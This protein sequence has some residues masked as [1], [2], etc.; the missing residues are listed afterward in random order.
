MGSA[1][2][3]QEETQGLE[4]SGTGQSGVSGLRRRSDSAADGDIDIDAI[5]ADLSR[6]LSDLPRLFTERPTRPAP[7][8]TAAMRIGPADA[9]TVTPI[10]PTPGILP[11]PPRA[12]HPDSL[13]PTASLPPAH[14]QRS[15]GHDL[16]MAALVETRALKSG[17]RGLLH[18]A[19]FFATVIVALLALLVMQT[20]TSSALPAARPTPPVVAAP[21][22][23]KPA[24]V[25][26]V[27]T[28]SPRAAVFRIDQ[29]PW[30]AG[31]YVAQVPK[32]DR[33]HDV[34]VAANGYL[35]RNVKVRFTKD[36]LFDIVLQRESPGITRHKAGQGF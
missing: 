24:V 2:D 34:Y 11:P 9:E 15:P 25:E 20:G 28:T 36:T 5:E 32:D 6:Q 3:E 21:A 29:G 16:M 12:P 10:R 23:S 31:P 14:A 35:P 18:G 7:A 19:T 26:I 22:P 33:E 4:S 17:L 1:Y 8:M 30:L 13:T 27:L